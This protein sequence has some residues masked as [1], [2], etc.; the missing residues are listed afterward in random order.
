[1]AGSRLRRKIPEST[2]CSGI[3]YCPR[4]A[5][6]WAGRRKGACLA[7][8]PTGFAGE[9][10]ARPFCW[11]AH[12]RLVARLADAC[13]A[14]AGAAAVSVCSMAP[15]CCSGHRRRCQRTADGP[16]LALAA[17]GSLILL[18]ASTCCRWGM[19]WCRGHQPR[20]C[21]LV[22]PEMVAGTFSLPARWPVAERGDGDG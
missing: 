21:G 4:R 15:A 12:E 14:G 2:G 6:G 1:M 5:G 17:L 19:A 9:S 3:Q 11:G 10:A 20:A 18:L 22:R 8:R 7:R 13:L 16:A